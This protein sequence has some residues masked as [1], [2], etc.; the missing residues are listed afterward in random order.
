MKLHDA[1]IIAKWYMNQLAPFCERIQIAGSI[2]RRKAE[3]GDIELVA[4]PKKV[5]Q[6]YLFDSE[7]VR[8]PEFVETVEKLEKVRGDARTGKY[9]QRM[10]PE[11]I[12]L[13]LFMASPENWGLILAIRTGSAAFIKELMI[14]L[15]RRGLCSEDG[16]VKRK[17]EEGEETIL[18]RCE[19]DV[20]ELAG[21]KW[22]EP[23]ERI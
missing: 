21:L 13:D 5:M 2:R 18:T 8:H 16:T 7:P 1:E 15:K 14:R 6:A 23:A 22:I 17:T 3:V 10:L 11:G 20:F 4:I 19:K 12:A 9:T